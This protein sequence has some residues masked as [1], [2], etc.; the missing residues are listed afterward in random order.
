[1]PVFLYVICM[2]IPLISFEPIDG[3]R[4]TRGHTNFVLCYFRPIV[5]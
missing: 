3:F 4:A 1:M 5:Y 2:Y